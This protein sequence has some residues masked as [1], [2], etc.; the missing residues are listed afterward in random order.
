MKNNIFITVL[1]FC[2]LVLP[3]VVFAQPVYK[4]LV[5][6]PGVSDPANTNFNNY[7]NT[8][9]GLSIAIAALLAVIK[10]IIAGVKYMLSDMVS[11]KGAAKEDIQSALLGLLIIASAFL[12]L[13]EINPNLTQTKLIT[14]KVDRPTAYNRGPAVST[15]PL[16][17]STTAP[18]VDNTGVPAGEARWVEID[19][20]VQPTVLPLRP[21]TAPLVSTCGRDASCQSTEAQSCVAN[22]GN[23]TTIGGVRQCVYTVNRQMNCQDR[24]V[25]LPTTSPD[26]NPV[27]RNDRDCYTA[28][29]MCMDRTP[30]IQETAWEQGNFSC[31]QMY[32]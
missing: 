22:R 11:S 29:A 23:Y 20:P 18:R 8:I 15:N 9:Y 3:T 17:N 16:S 6:I 5:G 28:L 31:N 32:R 26:G 14:S 25:Q 12:I 27:Y 30:E 7:I 19:G 2:I 10:I 21:S 1:T 24:R 13:N 4:P